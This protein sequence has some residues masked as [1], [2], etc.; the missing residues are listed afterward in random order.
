MQYTPKSFCMPNIRSKYI[1]NSLRHICQIMVGK[2]KNCTYSKLHKSMYVTYKYVFYR[3]TFEL[4]SSFGI[5]IE[6][7]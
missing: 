2:K 6:I 4:L 3:I 5:Y 1:N 7:I